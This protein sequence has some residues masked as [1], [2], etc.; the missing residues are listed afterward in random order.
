MIVSV[1]YLDKI[2]KLN[3]NFHLTEGNMVSFM[4]AALLASVKFFRDN[5]SWNH[6]LAK[7][8]NI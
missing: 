8:F 3:E 1:I 7:V 2:H 5:A 4:A 6:R